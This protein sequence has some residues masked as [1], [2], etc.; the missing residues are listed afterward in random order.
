MRKNNRLSSK[1]N[2][3]AKR[4][5]C[6]DDCKGLPI[7]RIWMICLD[8]WGHDCKQKLIWPFG[9]KVGE[10]DQ[11]ATKLCRL[12]NIYTKFQVEKKVQKNRTDGQ[13][14]RQTDIATA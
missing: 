1:W 10:S 7:Y 8:L 4:N 9:C 13:V 6:K 3:Y 5:L 2:F 14:G 12:L 11:I